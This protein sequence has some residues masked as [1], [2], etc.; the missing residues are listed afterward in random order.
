MKR[1]L[2]SVAA[3]LFLLGSVRPAHALQA[4][5]PDAALEEIATADKVETVVKHLPVKVEAYIQK[6][7]KQE[8]AAL[9][10][11][12]LVGKAMER[13]GIKLAK[14]GDGNSWE[15]IGK[16]DKRKATITVKKTFI[17]GDD[18]L[19]QLEVHQ[20]A[21]GLRPAKLERFNSSLLVGMHYENYEWRVIEAGMWEGTNLESQF[22]PKEE[23]KQQPTAAAAA[24]MLRTLNTSLITYASTYPDQ[25]FPS[26]LSALSGQENQEATPDHAMIVEPAFLQEP[27]VKDG[28]EFRYVRTAQDTYQLTATPLQFAE[29]SQSFFTD[30]S[31]VIRM[32]RES[33]P[34]TAQDPP[35]E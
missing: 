4:G 25:G 28:Y 15:V 29:G 6:L 35:V 23:P 30:E 2:W 32:T 14:S 21:A 8:R 9:A 20:E 12:L 26:A 34:A 13:E 19:V 7:P 5:T 27:T 31:A 16:D 17:S 10:E 11:K 33:R 1:K 18:A 24:S 22:L 3:T